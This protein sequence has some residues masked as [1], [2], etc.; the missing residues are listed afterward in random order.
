MSLDWTA[1]E[2]L[3]KSDA[4]IEALRGDRDLIAF[5]K[6]SI[7]GRVA[8][9]QTIAIAWRKHIRACRI[10]REAHKIALLTDPKHELVLPNFIHPSP[11]IWSTDSHTMRCLFLA[12]AWLRFR[13]LAIPEP[14]A[15]SS[16]GAPAIMFAIQALDIEF[17]K[18]KAKTNVA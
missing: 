9:T 18:T 10:V 3:L 14:K 11:G 1:T 16:P 12:Y 7:K 4:S 17:R 2:N 15:K 13:P 5:A 8:T 6:K